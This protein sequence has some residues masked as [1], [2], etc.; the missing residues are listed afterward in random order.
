MNF[1]LFLPLF[2]VFI[3]LFAWSYIYA[4]KRHTA[5]NRTCLIFL[6]SLLGWVF[7]DFIAWMPI[8]PGWKVPLFRIACIFWIP[9]GFL[10]LNFTYA[11]LEREK[12]LF[13]KIMLAGCIIAVCLSLVTDLTIGGHQRTYWG[14][15]VVPGILFV[16]IILLLVTPSTLYAYSLTLKRA[17]KTDDENQRRQLRLLLLGVTISLSIGLVCDV[18]LPTVM[19]VHDFIRLG[20]S[21]CGAISICAFLAVIKYNF[22]SVGVEKAAT[23]LFENIL[24]GIIVIDPDGQITVMN[25]SAKRMFYVADSELKHLNITELMADHRSR[26]TYENREIKIIRKDEPRYLSVSQSSIWEKGIELGKLIIVRDFTD[27]RITEEKNKELESQLQK[28]Q[29]MEMVG[30]LAGGVAN[31]LNRILSGI[32]SYPELVLLHLPEGS[33]LAKP[34]ES[35]QAAGLK[36]AEVVEDLLAISRGTGI[37]KEISNLNLIIEEYL[38]SE[39]QLEIQHK[40][41]SITYEKALDPDLLNLNC[42]KI[43]LTKAIMNLVLHASESINGAFGKVILTTR[44]CYLD[45]PLNGYEQVRGGEYTLL[46]VSDN[47]PHI[48]AEDLDRIFEPFYTKKR[49]GR[50]AGGLGLTVVWN[51]LKE[52]HGYKDVKS[53]ENGT[54]F[55]LY[56]PAERVPMNAQRNAVCFQEFEGF[57]QRI[58]VVDDEE[59]Q[60]DIAFRLLTELNYKA[61]T[62]VSGE[63]AVEYVKRDTFDLILLDMVMP[64]GMNGLRTYEEIIKINPGQKAVIASG[65]AL[66]EE[67]RAVQ[68]LGAG[69][70]IRKPYVL[71][72]LG[73]AIRAELEKS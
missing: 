53:G 38:A 19:K 51:I 42:S 6:A 37:N 1:F 45:K 41:P 35:I 58:L 24:D 26:D 2:S 23:S 69:R 32:I 60:R 71:E 55:E 13:Y 61:A 22:L 56:F 68:I 67:V 12:D 4:Q 3:G 33:P 34:V 54:V 25:E 64:A 43:H 27:I 47:G 73:A 29:K 14:E 7:C 31:D 28:A 20:S 66:M 57:G 46:S 40:Y 11:F 59:Q 62:A 18:F 63:A 65:C 17:L 72:K 15:M 5:V 49:M 9:S 16:P 48:P 30:L 50:N 21:G 8:P 36:A 44:N 39:E 52:H 10:F 70:Y